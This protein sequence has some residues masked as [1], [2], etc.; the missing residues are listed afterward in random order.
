M[1]GS[2]GDVKITSIPTAGRR[3]ALT[4]IGTR[5]IYGWS[6]GKT[7]ALKIFFID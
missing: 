3:W 7:L 5:Y 2:L 4:L 6:L 1:L